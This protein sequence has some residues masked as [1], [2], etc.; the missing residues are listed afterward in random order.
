M[1]MNPSVKNVM[2]PKE[3][4]NIPFEELFAPGHSACAGCG[5]SMAVR[6][7]T[8]ALGDDTIIVLPTGC[9]EVF[10]TQYNK[11]SWRLPVIHMLFENASAVASGVEAAMKRLKKDTK[12]AIIG[13]DGATADIGFGSLSGMLERGH[14]VIYICLDNEAYMNTG[15]QRSGSTP[16]AAHTTTSPSGSKSLGNYTGKKDLV[17]IVEAHGVDYVATASIAYPKDLFSKVR[18]AGKG[19]AYI[20]VHTPCPTGWGFDS[21]D[22][23]EIGKLALETCLWVNYEIVKGKVGN[24]TKVNRKPVKD[25]LKAQKRYR[26]LFKSDEGKEAIKKLQKIADF[27]AKKFGIA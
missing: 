18:K 25:Y 23:I 6:I 1:V 16:F 14:E 21:A 10:S 8:K 19:P 20:H 5:E 27:N 7:I 17:S 26:H 3:I 2:F 15:V 22:T 24:V 4:S 13:G 9:L 11:S 12:V